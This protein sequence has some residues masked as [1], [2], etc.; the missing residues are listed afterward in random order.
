VEQLLLDRGIAVV[1]TRVASRLLW[2]ALLAIGV[3]VLLEGLT[4]EAAQIHAGDTSLEIFQAAQH[5]PQTF[6]LQLTE[7]GILRQKGTLS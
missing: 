4:S 6:L 7:R 2:Q 3:V 1:R 5:T